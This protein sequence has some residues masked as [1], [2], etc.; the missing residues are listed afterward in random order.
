MCLSFLFV[1][2]CVYHLLVCEKA[3]I[4]DSYL[5]SLF[6]LTQLPRVDMA[7]TQRL[8]RMHDDDDDDGDAVDDSIEAG[9]QNILLSRRQH[10]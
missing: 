7:Y 3:C 4:H 9:E 2:V 1:C 5:F 8:K 6:F 10:R